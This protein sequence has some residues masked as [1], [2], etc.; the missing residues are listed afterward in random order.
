[1]VDP[2]ARTGDPRRT[3]PV[4]TDGSHFTLET[5]DPG[6]ILHRVHASKYCPVQFNPGPYGD[7]RFSPIVNP[8]GGQIATMYAGTTQECALMETVFRSVPYE[9]GYKTIDEA[10]FQDQIYSTVTL[11]Q[12]LHLVYLRSV[13]LRKIGLTREQLIDTEMDRYPETRKIAEAI[14]AL[15]PDAQGLYWVS[16]QDDSARAV[17]LF[18]DRIPSGA[19]S[20]GT[21][22][23]SLLGDHATHVAVL[24]LADKLGVYIVPGKPA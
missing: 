3:L 16:R 2:A 23:P 20:P 4:P 9:P 12:P 1:M 17:V 21:S 18:G 14:Y 13:A 10:K 11:A 8:G 22:S 6:R 15:R 7:A 19:L 5:L 24:D